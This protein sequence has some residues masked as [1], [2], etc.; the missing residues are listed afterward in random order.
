ML[1]FRSMADIE[2]QRPRIP[3]RIINCLTRVMQGLL[4][5][6]KDYDPEDDGYVVLIT[7][8]TTNADAVELMGRPWIDAR[9]E[10]VSYDQ[11]S[12]CFNACVLFNNQFGVSIIVP[13]DSWL[14]RIDPGFRDMLLYE[15]GGD[16]VKR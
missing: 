15:M 5:A 14:T 10:G 12:R 1:S 6:Y 9:L 3:P 16:N 11:E 2:A 8:Q 13:D 7:P 4:N